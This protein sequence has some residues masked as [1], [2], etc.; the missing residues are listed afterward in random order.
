M[1]KTSVVNEKWCTHVCAWT[2]DHFW[3]YFTIVEWI[4][5][6]R[7]F[8]KQMWHHLCRNRI[9]F[10]NGIHMYTF[11]HIHTHSNTKE[12]AWEETQPIHWWQLPPGRDAGSGW[13]GGMMSNFLIL[14]IILIL[15]CYFFFLTVGIDL[16]TVHLFFKIGLEQGNGAV[17]KSVS[18]WKCSMVSINVSQQG[19]LIVHV[20]KVHLVF[21]PS[22]F[23]DVC[24]C[25]W[26]KEAA[27]AL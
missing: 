12:K 26:N 21:H 13:W 5:Q 25:A 1:V 2:W 22:F 3:N 14:F 15:C 9:F 19:L 16:C 6:T 8:C 17:S 20:L 23:S 10:Q 4:K 7:V 11:M 18:F 24:N 27:R